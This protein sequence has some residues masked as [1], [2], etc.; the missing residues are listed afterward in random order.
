MAAL[1][2]A[3]RRRNPLPTGTAAVGVGLIVAGLSAYGFLFFADRA[4]SKAEYSPLGALWSMVFLIGPGLFLPLE[5]EISRALAERRAR[6]RGACRS[7]GE[8]PP[9][10]PGCSSPSR[11][12]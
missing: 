12:C 9:S 4:L 3:A 11:S 10:A 5:Q 8:P 1:L 6:F 2:E 7:S